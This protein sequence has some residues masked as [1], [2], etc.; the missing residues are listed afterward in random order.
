MTSFSQTYCG[1]NP[2]ISSSAWLAFF[3]V[4]GASLLIALCSQIKFI[5]PFTPVPLTFQTFAILMIG[6]TMG[7]R[8]GACAVLCYFAEILMGLP[9]LSG[10]MSDPLVFLGPKGGYVLGFCLQAYIMGWF[11]EKSFWPRSVMIAAGGIVSCLV[12]MSMGIFMLAQYVGWSH[13]WTM[14]LLPFVPGEILKIVLVSY[15][16]SPKKQTTELTIRR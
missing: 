16:I 11:V 10:G 14:G 3:Q 2:V 13:V 6:A 4:L 8:K 12:Q 15:A 1:K 9:V 5:L 7:S